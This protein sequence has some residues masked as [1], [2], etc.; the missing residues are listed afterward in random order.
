MTQPACKTVWQLLIELNI[1]LQ[2]GPVIPHPSAL[3]NENLCSHKNLY[4]D[5]QMF[6]C[7]STDNHQKLETI[8]ISFSEWMNKQTSIAQ[9]TTHQQKQTTDRVNNLD[10]FQRYYSDWKKLI[11]KCY[12][13]HDPS[14]MTPLK[15]QNCSEGDNSR[16]T[17]SYEWREWSYGYKGRAWRSSSGWCKYSVT[18]S[19]WEG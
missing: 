18:W 3:N 17:R 4:T 19:W 14:Y 8:Q 6:I 9:N 7:S 12:S 11:S 10:E 13:L 15:R 5:A 1:H 2:Y 16:V